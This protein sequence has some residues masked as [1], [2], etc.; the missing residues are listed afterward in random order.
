MS[1]IMSSAISI[2]GVPCALIHFCRSMPST[3]SMQM[4]ATSSWRPQSMTWMMF[5]WRIMAAARASRSKRWRS[6]SSSA[7]CG[8]RI[9]STTGRWSDFCTARYTDAMPPL[10]IFSFSSNAPKSLFIA[11]CSK[12]SPWGSGVHSNAQ[13]AGRGPLAQCRSARARQRRAS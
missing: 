9:L 11:M 10:P 5:S 6:F 3:N 13:H 1:R 8:Y 7:R 2:G 12:P 4:Y